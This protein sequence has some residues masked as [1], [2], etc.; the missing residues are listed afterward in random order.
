MKKRIGNRTIYACLLQTGWWYVEA[1]TPAGAVDAWHRFIITAAELGTVIPDAAVSTDKFLSTKF[2]DVA[3]LPVEELSDDYKYYRG[4]VNRAAN[5]DTVEVIVRADSRD[6]AEGVLAA[7]GRMA[8]GTGNYVAVLEMPDC[9][10]V[11]LRGEYRGI[12][13][14]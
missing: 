3:G 11:V 9:A 2:V 14:E 12:T 4:F 6:E 8:Y 5:G 13:F 7:Y 1:A 10:G